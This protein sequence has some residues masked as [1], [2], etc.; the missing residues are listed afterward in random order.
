ML[1]DASLDESSSR[2][3]RASELLVEKGISFSTRC[4]DIYDKE[5]LDGLLAGFD[6]QDILVLS[7]IEPSEPEKEDKRIIELILYLRSYRESVG[8][9]FG[10]TCQIN[11]E[12]NRE[13]V[14]VTGRD[15]YIVSRH[16]A[17]LLMAQVSQKREMAE[18]CNIILSSEGFEVYIKKALHY[19][20]LEVDVDLYS[21]GAA[22]AQRGDVFIGLRQ[23]RDGRYCDLIIN[24]AKHESDGSLKTYRFTEDDFFV[25]LAEGIGF[26][27]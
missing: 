15:D 10:I 23:R 14:D 27:A 5:C 1:A 2:F 18:L 9:E 7:D 26:K 6:P 12:S 3:Q 16:F 24:P 8:H 4:V 22:V 19:V 13:L 25:V 17:A 11:S 20:P 21:A